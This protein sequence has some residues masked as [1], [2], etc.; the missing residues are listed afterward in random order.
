MGMTVK[1]FATMKGIS[2]QAVYKAVKAGRLTRLPDGTI[3]PPTDFAKEKT[4]FITPS[5]TAPSSSLTQV[6]I[7]HEMLKA[8][9]TKIELA[10]M[11]GNSLSAE[12]VESVFF[13]TFRALRDRIQDL[14]VRLA[15]PLVALARDGSAEVAASAVRN[16]ITTELNSILQEVAD[17]PSFRKN[18]N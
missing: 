3:E 2:T 7:A 14:P 4:G 11:E 6:R 1:E 12:E 13:T 10:A 17:G 9:K 8:K 16:M 18:K 15:D 5:P